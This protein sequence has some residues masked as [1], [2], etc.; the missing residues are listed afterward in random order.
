MKRN[1]ARMKAQHAPPAAW[2]TRSSGAVSEP[3]TTANS[4]TP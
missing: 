3:F 1:Q 4:T 2:H